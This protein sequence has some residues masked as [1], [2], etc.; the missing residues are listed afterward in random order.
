MVASLGKI[1]RTKGSL[2]SIAR[3]FLGKEPAIHPG[4]SHHRALVTALLD[5]R[6]GLSHRA[7]PD[8]RNYPRLKYSEVSP[9]PAARILS[10]PRVRLVNVSPGGVLLDAPF[11]LRP[12]SELVLEVSTDPA[13]TI[14]RADSFAVAMQVLRCY[15]SELKDGVRYH[16]AGQ[17]DVGLISPCFGCL[18]TGDWNRL[19]R[20][21]ESF[22]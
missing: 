21:L 2:Q 7:E 13:N 14:T 22:R 11:Q 18:N 10:R 6:H 4:V 8:R 19:L 12:G 17:F 1:G 5:G 9:P 15:V 16:A 3:D 20:I